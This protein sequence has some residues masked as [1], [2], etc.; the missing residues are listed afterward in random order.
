MNFYF[1]NVILF[2]ITLLIVG[3]KEVESRS[4]ERH[5]CRYDCLSYCQ[6]SGKSDG[7]CGHRSCICRQSI[8]PKM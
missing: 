2:L 6:T 8:Q 7:Y 5:R 1:I 4:V 3:S